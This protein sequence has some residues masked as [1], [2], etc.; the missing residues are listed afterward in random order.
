MDHWQVQASSF[1]FKKESILLVAWIQEPRLCVIPCHTVHK[2]AMSKESSIII[3]IDW[4][5][6]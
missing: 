1:L 2:Q 5:C 3:D 4:R 6:E